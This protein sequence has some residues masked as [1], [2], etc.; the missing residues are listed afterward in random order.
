MHANA[1]ISADPAPACVGETDIAIIAMD[2]RFP[3]AGD[4]EELWQVLRDGRETVSHFSV[5]EMLEAGVAADRLADPN[6]VRAKGVLHGVEYFDHEF[7]GFSRLEAEVMDPQQRLFLEFTW[8]V[9]ERA[10]YDAECFDGRIGLFAG[11]AFN[12]YL[13]NNLRHARQSHI[14]R[15]HGIELLIMSDKDFL[16]MLTAHHLGLRGPVMTVQTACS[17]AAVAV[18][19]ACQALLDAECDMALAGA[20]TVYSPQVKGYVYE[21][22]N[23]ISPDGHVR[24]FDAA[25][26]G[27]VY[28]SGMGM[29]VL[30]RLA[31]AVRDGDGVH[32]VIKGSAV[33][34]DGGR[35]ALFKAP[36]VDGIAEVAATALAVSDVEPDRIRM[37][38]ANGSGTANGDPIEVEALTR[39]YGSSAT[40]SCAIGS[41]KSNVGHLNVAA[42]M[43]ALLKAALAVERGEIPPTINFSAPNP[44]IRFDDGPFYVARRLEP[45]PDEAAGRRVAAVNSYGV[46]GTNAHIVV[47]QP[48]ALPASDP[49]HGEEVIVVSART[50]A[51]LER[52][53]LR[54]AQRLEA[55]EDLPPLADVCFTLQV[56]RRAFAHRIAVAGGD[57]AELAA[58][59]RDAPARH[60]A[61]ERPD[62][63]LWWCGPA[64]LDDATPVAPPWASA[65]WSPLRAEIAAA[66]PGGRP[67]DA[68]LAQP[69]DDADRALRT[70]SAQLLA[71]R[72]L[73]PATGTAG[74]DGD[75]VGAVTAAVAAGRSGIEDAVRQLVGGTNGDGP[76]GTARPAVRRPAAELHVLGGAV[77]LARQEALGP[78]A[79]GH[80][81]AEAVAELW[82]RGVPID[83]AA[84]HAG[85]RRRRVPLPTYSFERVRCWVDIPADA[86]SH[87]FDAAR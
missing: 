58:R 74:F 86:R 34:N 26:R 10:G 56:G 77:R 49:G 72:A 70:F 43:A 11:Q 85:L 13:L 87:V 16:S 29:V 45:W 63:P 17:T 83:W 37:M 8:H 81:W 66:L 51:A 1:A 2:C 12:T 68:A 69:G 19:Q 79:V 64:L 6:Y 46:G 44:A 28:S 3:G 18:H 31:D 4:L 76:G 35:K 78:A 39:A 23:L 80:G 47:E 55:A 24:S 5:E 53:R 60:V 21:P 36:S 65:V 57:A 14:R 61:G 67:L 7:F 30:K 22:G 25:G 50:P 32:A 15:F 62:A 27:T 73:A 33:G 40:A 54:L 82:L 48:P 42:G 20:I 59:L 38:E 71:L 84:L 9:L 75:G 41:V 52:M